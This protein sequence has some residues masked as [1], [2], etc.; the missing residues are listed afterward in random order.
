MKQVLSVLVLIVGGGALLF[1]AGA[2]EEPEPDPEVA[3]VEFME[4]ALQWNTWSD[5]E[6]DTGVS[7]DR[8][9]EAPE[10]AEL[11]AAGELEPV[12]ERLPED[13]PVMR[14]TEAVGEYGGTFRRAWLGPG[15]HWSIRHHLR[16]IPV[17]M[18]QD[19]SI[20]PNLFKDYEIIGDGE[21]YIFHMREGLRWDDGELMDAYDAE[22][23]WELKLDDRLYHPHRSEYLVDGQKPDIEVID[24]YTWRITFPGP[25]PLFLEA[26]SREGR[27]DLVAPRHYLEQ[28][29]ADYIS[30]AAMQRTLEREGYD[31]WTS[32][33][34]SK[35][36]I[37]NNPERPHWFA[38]RAVGDPADSEYVWERNPY[39][40]KVD[41]E[42]KQLPYLDDYR[43]EYVTERE[44]IISLA[45]G[46]DISGQSR[47]IDIENW[48]LL[49]DNR[50][51]GGY[52]VYPRV[53]PDIGSHGSIKFNLTHHD[54]MIREVFQD[55]RFRRAMSSA[56]DREEINEIVL[57]GLG[58][59]RQMAWTRFSPFYCEEWAN[60]YVEHDPDLANELLDDMGL[61]WGDDGYRRYPDGSR[62][63]F[64][65]VDPDARRTATLE[66]LVEHWAEV[67]VDLDID[68]QERTLW[69]ERSMAGNY[70][71]Q[72]WHG[73][74]SWN[75]HLR[76]AI[77][78]PRERS[79]NA[80]HWATE[81]NR[82]LHSGGAAGEEPPPD[83]ARTEELI[84]RAQGTVDP[85]ERAEYMAELAEWHKENLPQIGTVG[86]IPEP[87]VVQNNLRNAHVFP[88]DHMYVLDGDDPFIPTLWWDD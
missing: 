79:P 65:I 47:H 87:M 64:S 74:R 54:P 82:Y 6:A 84:R 35:Y 32:M 10:L 20:A 56:M 5:Y 19:G 75:P 9:Q 53:D 37:V 73:D 60:A 12:E 14:A 67:G 49:M 62:L 59:P 88:A 36:Q 39:Y 13:P 80:N 31:E 44:L 22:F 11:V 28:F 46:G 23:W 1:A 72:I 42:G 71:A 25:N 51:R 26:V 45:I 27:A 78:S 18:T 15:D 3:E 52:E 17:Y 29:H 58:T 41:E 83:V 85:D 68:V 70:D 7:I 69:E 8:F 50:V 48:A 4:E 38:F 34:D 81:W 57:F 30:D 66:L 43:N 55:V 16:E 76:P 33:M 21:E 63:R 77:W 2:A 86:D 24:Q 40:F 61:E